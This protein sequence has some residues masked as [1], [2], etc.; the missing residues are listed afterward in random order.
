MSIEDE[1]HALGKLL[2]LLLFGEVRRTV[3]QVFGI[4]VSNGNG[5]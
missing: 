3:E 1:G 2:D 5:G 4:K